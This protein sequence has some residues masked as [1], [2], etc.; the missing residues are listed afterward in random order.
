[1][2]VVVAAQNQVSNSWV[3]VAVFVVIDL[4]FILVVVVLIAVVVVDVV[5]VVAY[6]DDDQRNLPLMID[7][8]WFNN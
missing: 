3:I 8:N 4:V 7:Q 1:M 6:V 5:V 2:F